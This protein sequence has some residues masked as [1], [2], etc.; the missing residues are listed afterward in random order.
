MHNGCHIGKL[1]AKQEGPLL[2]AEAS[3]GISRE[4]PVTLNR[5][6][7]F[8]RLTEGVKTTVCEGHKPHNMSTAGHSVRF[9]LETEPLSVP[10]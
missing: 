2:V 9:S 5:H 8:E 3:D 10:S 1:L 7:V 6:C 4:K